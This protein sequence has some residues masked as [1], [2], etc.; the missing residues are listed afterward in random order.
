MN[1]KTIDLKTQDGI[2]DTYVSYPE[3]QK[4]L[5]AILLY[6]DAIGL[7][8]RIEEMADQM[9]AKGYFVIAPNLFYR[10]RRAPVFD[11]SVLPDRA[12]LFE[13]IM[14]VASQLKTDMA[15]RDARAFIDFI[16]AQPQVNIKKMGTVGYCMGGAHALRTAG[17]FPDTF[18]AVATYHVG[19]A[20]WNDPSSPHHWFPKIKAEVYMGHADND[21]HMPPAQMEQVEMFLTE[22]HIRHKTEL[23]PHCPHGWTMKDMPMYNAEG[24]QKHWKTLFELFDRVLKH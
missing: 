13:Q 16:K 14:P 6:I 10:T 5:P 1:K 21:Q 22:N 12:K 8:P 23:Y 20:V 15:E 2:C 24:E 19:N 9:A 11:Y 3:G 17:N 18:Q 7:R 4:N